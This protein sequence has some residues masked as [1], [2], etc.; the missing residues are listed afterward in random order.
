MQG[1]ASEANGRAPRLLSCNLPRALSPADGPPRRAGCV[2]GST[3]RPKCFWHSQSLRRLK[4]AADMTELFEV[5]WGRFLLSPSLVSSR[6]DLGH[7]VLDFCNL[8]PSG[9]RFREREKLSHPRGPKKWSWKATTALFLSPTLL[10]KTP[11][12]RRA[13]RQSTRSVYRCTPL[14]SAVRDGFVDK[15]HQLLYDQSVALHFTYLNNFQGLRFPR[16]GRP[17]ILSRRPCWHYPRHPSRQPSDHPRTFFFWTVE[18]ATCPTAAPCLLR[19]AGSGRN[20]R[21]GIATSTRGLQV[22]SHDGNACRIAARSS[23]RC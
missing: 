18:S 11:S 9:D 19:P 8:Q 6:F 14:L 1:D 12:S 20:L 17:G 2:G 15:N 21:S 4:C 16:A 23:L 13:L 10:P 22:H 5:L 3:A 7:D